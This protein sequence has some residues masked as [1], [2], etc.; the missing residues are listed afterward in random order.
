MS[1][2]KLLV[3]QSR[4]LSWWGCEQEWVHLPIQQLYL[5]SFSISELCVPTSG[6]GSFQK[7]KILS[8]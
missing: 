7:V 3:M 2:E 4:A 1:W 6:V 8:I 5:L